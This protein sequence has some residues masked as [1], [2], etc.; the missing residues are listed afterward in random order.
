MTHPILE[1]I[2]Y[3][4][5]YDASVLDALEYAKSNGFAGIQ[6][7]VELPHLSFESLSEEQIR[8]VEAFAE[9]NGV[10]ITIH[11]PDEAASLFQHSRFLRE[12]IRNYYRALFE[13]AA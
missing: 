1:R 10:Y 7:A 5:V 4:A 9:S 13:F 3:H 11:A 6:L 12:G 2:S 8:E